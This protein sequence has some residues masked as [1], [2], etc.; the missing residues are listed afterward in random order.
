MKILN[1]LSINYWIE[2]YFIKYVAAFLEK[3]S[4]GWKTVSGLLILVVDQI[5]K[6]CSGSSCD[7]FRHVYEILNKLPHA[8]IQD[9]GIALLAAGIAGKLVNYVPKDAK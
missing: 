5:I 1:Y 8:T 6:L 3:S 9:A 7:A 2:E 4:K